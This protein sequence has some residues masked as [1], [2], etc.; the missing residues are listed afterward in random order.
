METFLIIYG[1]TAIVLFM[2]TYVFSQIEYIDYLKLALACLLFPIVF[3]MIIINVCIE[4]W[5]TRSKENN[6]EKN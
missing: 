5:Y 3:I 4:S 6:N 1:L 2:I